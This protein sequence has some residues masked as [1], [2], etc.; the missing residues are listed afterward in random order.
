[1]PKRIAPEERVIVS[2]PDYEG[3]GIYIIRNLVNG[4]IYVGSARNIKRR[5][6]EHD[7]YF[8]KG[9]CN[10]KI[11]AD[12]DLGHKFTSDILEKCS[13]MTF[14]EM[15]DREDYYVQKYDCYNTGYNSQ[16]VPTYRL[17][18]YKRNKDMIEWLTRKV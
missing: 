8:R 16:W 18:D 15:R 5:M 12:I 14:V 6:K 1:M 2:I 10:N 11:Q 7:Y 13:G 3:P 17:K 9:Y 4:R